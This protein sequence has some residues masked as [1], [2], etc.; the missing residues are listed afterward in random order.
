MSNRA[1]LLPPE[2]IVELEKLQDQ[3]PPF[4]GSLAESIIEEELGEPIATIFPVF[5]P[6]PVA[7]ASIAQVHE[8]YLRDGM[9][10]AV[11]IQRPNIEP[12]ILRDLEILAMIASLADRHIAELRNF[13][14]RGMVSEFHKQI[15]KELDFTQEFHNMERFGQMFRGNNAIH[16][17][18][19]WKNLTTRKVLT[20]EYVQGTKL[21]QIIDGSND[22]FDR[23]LI[24][25]RLAELM[26]DQ[27]F[28][29][30]FFHADPHPGNVMILADNVACFLDFG[31]MGRIFPDEQKLL[32]DLLVAMTASDYR[33]IT[34]NLLRLVGHNT[35]DI[36]DLEIEIADLLDLYFDRPMGEI[37][38]GEVFQR[39][40]LL[41]Q[42]HQLKVPSK[43]L[44][45]AKALVI[46][47]GIGSKL[48][49]DFSFMNLF[50][51]FARKMAM[52]KLRPDRLARTLF[53]KG[54][55]YADIVQEFP[56][57][58]MELLRGVQ[59]GDLTI[60]FRIRGIEPLRKTIDNVGT[61]MVFGI[62][63]AAILISS[64]LIIRAEIPPL[65]NGIPV[66][67]LIGF[68]IAGIMSFGFLLSII[69]RVFQKTR[70]GE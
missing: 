19:A 15:L 21:S 50:A 6:V 10:V 4:A 52:R 17:P 44:L 31:M 36:P 5:N 42:S 61:Q 16:V 37:D 45:M 63:L 33:Q 62:T 68:G 1:D 18:K 35:H 49:P 23:P 55:V 53:D 9:R 14:P 54:T 57:E 47:E 8:A 66:I 30:G 28:H 3:V 69:S 65:V 29:Y 48:S 32:I 26:L 58:A 2:L 67:G 39:L 59:R 20:M 13:D 38:F 56:I 70:K 24:A 40:V 22:H 25:G 43:L 41:V 64:S 60:N 7:S 46:S 51:P 11:K 27:V 34:V 12:M